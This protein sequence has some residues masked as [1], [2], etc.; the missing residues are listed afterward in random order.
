MKTLLRCVVR[1]PRHKTCKV[2]GSEEPSSNSQFPRAGGHPAVSGLAFVP[3]KRMA[4]CGQTKAAS[5]TRSGNR[6]RRLPP[7]WCGKGGLQSS[8]H[9]FVRSFI[10]EFAGSPVTHDAVS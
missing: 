2:P 8:V 4:R 7:T 10:L 1:A 6:E 5:A 3:G 9:S